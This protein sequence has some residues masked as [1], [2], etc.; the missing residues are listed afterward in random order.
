MKNFNKIISVLLTA[1]MLFGVAFCN[2][3]PVGALQ[4]DD[5]GVNKSYYKQSVLSLWKS[6]KFSSDSAE[7][8][9]SEHKKGSGLLI[10]GGRESVLN[11]KFMFVDPFNFDGNQISLLRV[12]ALSERANKLKL[13]FFIDDETEPFAEVSATRQ[14]RSGKWDT[15]HETAVNVSAKNIIGTH[16]IYFK[17]LS[18]DENADI[19]FVMRSAEFVENSLPVV[20]FNIDETEGTIDAMNSDPNHD[21]ECY[22]KMSLEVPNGYVS[23]Y[24]GE[25]VKSKIYDLDYIRGR[26]NSTWTENKKPYKIKLSK[27]SDLFGMGKNKHWVLLANAFDN[28]MIRN[29]ITYWLGDKMGMAYTPKSVFVDV[30]MNDNYYGTYQLCQQIRV[31]ES[32]VEIDDLE[33]D[34]QSMTATD[35]P[36]ITGG[37]LLSLCPYGDEENKSFTTEH[38]NEFL[39]ESPSFEDYYN[40][41]QYNYIKNY[42]SDL[43]RAIYSPDGTYNGKHFS[44]YM[45]LD[46]AA[47]YYVVQEF[48][49]NGDAYLSTSTY[50]Y[51]PRNGKLYW[52]PLWDF[53]YVAWG[54]DDYAIETVEGW[55]CNEMLWFSELFKNEEF[56]KK[57]ELYWNEFRELLKEASK[58]GGQIDRYAAEL[59]LSQ[60]YNFEKWGLKKQ[61]DIEEENTENN[62]RYTYS[63]E[64]TQLKNWINGRIDW[65]DSNIKS[66]VPQRYTVKFLKDD[67]SV[68]KVFNVNSNEQITFPKSLKKSGYTFSGWYYTDK[69]AGKIFVTN[70]EYPY[71]N[72]TLKP[73]WTDNDKTVKMKKLALDSSYIKKA[74]Y[75]EDINLNLFTV[76]YNVTYSEIEWKSNNEKVAE[77]DG[78]GSVSIKS[79]GKTSVT[80]TDKVSGLSAK[81]TVEIIDDGMY[82]GYSE[83]SKNKLTLTEGD[84]TAIRVKT[85]DKDAFTPSY[86]WMAS[87]Y[88]VVSVLGN[89]VVYGNKPG[90]AT[91]FALDENNYEVKTCEVTVKPATKLTK[92]TVKA[93]GIEN[94]TFTGKEIRQPKLTLKYKNRKLQKGIDY[95][96]SYKNNKNV[97]RATVTVKF[98]NTYSG[99]LTYEYNIKPKPVK[100]NKVTSKKAKMLNLNWGKGENISGYEVQLATNKTFKKAEK[101]TVGKDKTSFTIKN[102]KGR[103]KYYLRVRAYKKSGKKIFSNYSNVIGVKTK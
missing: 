94:R 39:I 48:S 10:S 101:I 13:A 11:S 19:S 31:G 76:P 84:C 97:G 40:E 33:K 20:Y 67:G 88:S 60:R 27:K 8:S 18:E 36:T 54:Q 32:R 85:F 46:S 82:D 16:N 62:A 95:I 12:D 81:C 26:G 96:L 70:G 80:A 77:V 37:Y 74:V 99:K 5:E 87:D 1:A 92:K 103:K 44:E 35:E 49:K 25:A 43:E 66:L 86:V 78:Y 55:T 21:T 83:L 59:E 64:V 45:D 102:L 65:V 2:A 7:V 73:A 58:D 47:K 28:S 63:D 15:V 100:L 57:V 72:M 17:V 3:V 23:E 34:E 9:F 24:S 68:Y 69:E 30:V 50:L 71:R 93:T 42:V 22:G 75:A 14:K 53:D 61:G 38:N 98:I 4:A 6:G 52:G 29:K 79:S 41:T 91:V 90:K 51:K 56:Y 89:G